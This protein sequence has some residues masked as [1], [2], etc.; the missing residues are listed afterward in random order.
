MRTAYYQIC[1]NCGYEKEEAHDPE[2]ECPECGG[3]L[4]GHRYL[5]CECGEENHYPRF[6]NVCP[7]CR[8]LYNCFG[9]EL[10]PVEEWDPEDR[11]ACFGPQN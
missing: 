10:A 6:T 3:P 9:Q 11:Y 2:V 5:I 4:G 7:R 1:K 8:K